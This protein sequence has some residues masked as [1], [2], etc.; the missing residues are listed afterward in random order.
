MLVRERCGGNQQIVCSDHLSAASQIGPDTGMGS[1]NLEIE[2]KDR[3]QIENR[4]DKATPATSAYSALG[5]MNAMQKLG[6]GDR[7]DEDRLITYRFEQTLR[8]LL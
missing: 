1:G 8:P 3:H 2:R 6:S 5:T 4:F 7:C